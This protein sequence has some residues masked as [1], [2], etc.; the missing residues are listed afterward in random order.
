[1]RGISQYKIGIYD[2]DERYVS[3]LMQYINQDVKNPI[4]ALG[5]STKEK[6]K[7]YLKEHHLDLLVTIEDRGHSLYEHCGEILY[8]RT[9]KV[10]SDDSK[11]S[12]YKYSRANEMLKQILLLL[13]IEA[14]SMKKDLYQTYGVI[15]PVGRSGKTRLA[16]ALCACDEVRGGLYLGM[17]EY[18]SILGADIVERNVM[19]NLFYLAK[20]R[21]PELI[22]YL[23]SELKQIDD[24][25]VL[26]SP[27][28][29]LDLRYITK[30]DVRFLL[31]EL[32]KWGRFTT[33]VCDIGGSAL[34]DISILETFDHLLMPTLGDENSMRKVERFM[35]LL[36]RKELGKLASRIRQLKLPNVEYREPAML[37]Y[38]E[39]ELEGDQ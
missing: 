25:H 31:D 13:R 14:S 23:E 38:L 7:G 6:L 2:T 29:Y 12:V 36:E 10:A 1:M 33:I 17:E 27:A 24:I 37:G 28:S 16:M 20:N 35:G 21:S 22:S 32:V 39:R 4:L 30:S 11:N 18:G 5:F 9:E 26:P 15:S 8:M 34:E 3:N 19:S